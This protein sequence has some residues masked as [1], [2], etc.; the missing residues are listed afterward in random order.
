MCS[1][2]RILLCSESVNIL[3]IC[4]HLTIKIDILPKATCAI[5]ISRDV[6][7]VLLILLYLK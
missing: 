4:V 7:N 5:K 1:P 6:D 3:Y 2:S